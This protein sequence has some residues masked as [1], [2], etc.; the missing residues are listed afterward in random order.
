MNVM[1]LDHFAALQK[2]DPDG[3]LGHAAALPKQCQE[4]WTATQDLALPGDYQNANKVVIAGMGGSAIGGDLAAAVAAGTSTIPVLVHRD[5]A[6]P[7]H[8]DAKT[9]V[10]AS[11]YSGNTE[12]TLAAF[13]AARERG[14]HLAAVTTGGELRRLA[15]EWHAPLVSFD[16][17]SQ[18]RAALGYLFISMLGI[19]RALDVLNDPTADLEEAMAALEDRKGLFAPESPLAQN[20]AK[21]LASRLFGKVPI[22]IAAGALVP[23]ARRWKTQLNENGKSWAYFEALPE[24]DHNALSGIHFPPEAADRS[25]VLLLQQASLHPRNA[26]RLDLTRQVLE[27]QGI[28]C[29]QVLV[30]GGSELAQILSAVQL[31]D[32]ASTYLALLYGADPTAIEDI[33]GLKEQMTDR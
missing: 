18:P 25:R 4:A 5:Y 1:N 7:A 19:L 28:G 9:L 21:Q 3:M 15:R 27:G 8:V 2:L 14:C 10:I 29:E 13:R 24:M 6:L 32:F 31:G 26:L 17:V 23:V 12:E 20:P 33:V 11:S 30:P 16:Y 22:V